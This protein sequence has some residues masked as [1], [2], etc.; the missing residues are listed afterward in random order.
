MRLEQAAQL[1]HREAGRLRM[2]L[3]E[4]ESSH[5]QITAELEEQLRRWAQEL[6]AECQ[7]LHLLMEQSGAK[8][9]SVQLPPR[10]DFPPWLTRRSG[11]ERSEHFIDSMLRLV[12]SF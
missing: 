8:H 2:M 1:A 11:L 4:R 5:K 6:G 3:E 10:Y 12:I 7:H 9:I